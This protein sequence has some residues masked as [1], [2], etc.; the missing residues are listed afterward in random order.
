MPVPD[1]ARYAKD[2]AEAIGARFEDLDAG[3]GY[4][5]RISKGERFVLGGGGN[6]CAYAINSAGAYTVSRD[7]AHTKSVL[8]SRGLAV[9]PGGLF[10]AQARRIA[11]RAPGREAM[12]AA[13]F[14]A[15]LGYP[16]FCKPN[17]GSGGTFAE[18]VRNEAALHDYVARVAVEFEAFLIEPLLEGAEHRVLVQDGR[19][20]FHSIKGEPALV[21]NGRSTLGELLTNLN[22]R[23]VASGVSPLPLSAISGDASRVPLSGERVRLPGRRNLSAAGAIEQVS[24]TVPTPLATLAI[25]ATEALSLRIGA[26]DMFDISASRDLSEL[27]V[28]EANGNPGLRTLEDAGRSDLIRAIWTRMLNACLSN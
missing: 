11:M 28:I 17:L 9:I 16:V 8:Q 22:Q 27:V 7:K 24:E 2:A 20:V 15:R 14:A 10:F 21:G 4:L 25:A 26:V 12:D 3:E 6:I 23:V 5:F 19:A 1:S 18:I 13:A